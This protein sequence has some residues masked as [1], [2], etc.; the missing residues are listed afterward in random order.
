VP[1][2]V[3]VLANEWRQCGVKQGDVLLL[4]SAVSR[5]LRRLVRYGRK[6]DV[7]DI[8]ASFMAALGDSGT[9]LLPLFNFDFSAGVPFDIRTTPSKMGALTEAGR[10]HADAVRTGHPIYS[11]AAIGAHADQFRGVTNYSGYGAD[12][13][14]GI[15]HRLG[16]SIAILDLSEQES[17]TFYHYVEEALDVPYR[18]HKAFE[19]DYTDDQGCTSRRAFGL[20][21][22]DLDRGIET[23]VDPMGERLWEMGLYTG[24][25][26]GQGAGLRVIEANAVYDATAGVIRAGQAHGLLYTTEP[27]SS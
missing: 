20:F 15:L 26:H 22:R 12:S 2:A 21:V 16:G 3:R 4:H 6:P 27:Q 9:L 5:T 8:L 18:Y 19:G 14:F 7:N 24:C 1:E 11:F 23:A 10:L 17:M 25:R 13:P